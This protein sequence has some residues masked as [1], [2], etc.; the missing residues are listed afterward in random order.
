MSRFIG[1]YS[2]PSNF[3]KM[4]RNQVNKQ[5]EDWAP[6]EKS[7]V[8]ESDVSGASGRVGRTTVSTQYTRLLFMNSPLLSCVDLD[9]SL[10]L[11]DLVP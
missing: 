4:N 8:L 10:N 6:M 11:S 3:S 7:T 5:D 9:S 2:E 1:S